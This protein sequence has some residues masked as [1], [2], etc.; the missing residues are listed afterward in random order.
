MKPRAAFSKLQTVGRSYLFP[1]TLRC[2][3]G[4]G[5]AGMAPTDLLCCDGATVLLEYYIVGTIG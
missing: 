5:Q 1:A 2:G 3:A 4:V